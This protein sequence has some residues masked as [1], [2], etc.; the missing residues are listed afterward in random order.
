[1]TT[2]SLTQQLDNFYINNVILDSDGQ[3]S[4]CFGFYDWFCKDSSLERKGKRLMK[5]VNTW[6]NKRVTDTDKVYVFFKNNCTGRGI[7]YDDFRIVDRET[8]DVIYT[9]IPKC[10]HSG[11]A[12]VWGRENGFK[13]AI[14]TGEN[15]RE[16]HEKSF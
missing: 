7:K 4:D 13:E 12:E 14:V 9:V 11:K 3:A 15:M 16:I 5:M 2:I 6:V 8:G 1:M 10:G